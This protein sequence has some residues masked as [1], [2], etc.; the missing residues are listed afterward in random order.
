MKEII[1]HKEFMGAIIKIARH[2]YNE[3]KFTCVEVFVDRGWFMVP[4]RTKTGK[5]RVLNSKLRM[6]RKFIR[7]RRKNPG[8]PWNPGSNMKTSCTWEL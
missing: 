7:E 1:T 6:A 4:P 2:T 5:L 8:A 3:T